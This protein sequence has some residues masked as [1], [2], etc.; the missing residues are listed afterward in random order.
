MFL[1]F[2]DGC[3]MY[4]RYVKYILKCRYYIDIKIM[5]RMKY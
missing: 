1:Y 2:Y 4:L 3:D 5:N